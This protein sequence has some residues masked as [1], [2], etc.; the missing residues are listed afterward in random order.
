[1][2]YFVL[3]FAALIVPLSLIVLLAPASRY[4][5]NRQ[6]TNVSVS[7]KPTA[8]GLEEMKQSWI[9]N[10]KL[11]LAY[12]QEQS[13][14]RAEVIKRRRR[15]QSG[16]ISKAEL[17]EA[18]RSFVAALSHIQEV[19][20]SMAENDMAITEAAMEDELIR[21]PIPAVNALSETSRLSR[22]N[23]GARWSLN[24]ASIVEEFYS[25][26]FG[27]TLP[28]T[29]YGQTATHNRM[30]F[31]HRDAMDIALHPDSAEGRALIDHLRR[32]GIP[33]IAFKGAVAGASTGA[34]IHIGRPSQRMAAN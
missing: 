6:D 30:R 33:F 22:F 15:Y 7:R 20:H 29:A 24:Q 34:H 28:V 11:L 4:M 17:V 14:L 3:F 27:R 16:A 19:R 8:D 18:E 2:R 21:L 25:Q 9:K 32:S 13:K 31:D 26:K 1:M 5:Q 10:Q 23:G 12:E